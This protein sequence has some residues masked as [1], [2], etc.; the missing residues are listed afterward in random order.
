MLG[1]L[2]VANHVDWVASHEIVNQWVVQ[3]EAQKIGAADVDNGDDVDHYEEGTTECEDEGQEAAEAL[4]TMH[5]MRL[6]AGHPHHKQ[7]MILPWS[8]KPSDISEREEITANL[9]KYLDGDMGH[10]YR[11]VASI[12]PC[13]TS[14]RCYYPQI[15][16]ESRCLASTVRNMSLEWLPV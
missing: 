16:L 10:Q 11:E 3:Q 5:L 1:A 2:A 4:R 8:A 15:A 13:L 7:Q 14:Y 6:L 12:A 9:P